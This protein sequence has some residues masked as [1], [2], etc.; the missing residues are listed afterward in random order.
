MT[1]TARAI[2]L[3]CDLIADAVLDGI[4]DSQAALGVDLGTLR[5]PAVGTG[6]EASPR[7]KSLLPKPLPR[8]PPGERSPGC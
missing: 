8:K 7:L 5:A 6:A 1:M 2:A 4:S 3:Y